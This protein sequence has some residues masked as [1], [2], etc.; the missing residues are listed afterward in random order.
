[1]LDRIQ[2][3]D[4]VTENAQLRHRAGYRGDDDDETGS[5]SETDAFYTYDNTVLQSP[6]EINSTRFTTLHGYT[7]EQYQSAQQ[8]VKDQLTGSNNSKHRQIT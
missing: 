8:F 6:Y 4:A 2:R 7:S 5:S 1:M 3:M